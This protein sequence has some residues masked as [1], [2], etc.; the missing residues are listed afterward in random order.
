MIWKRRRD[1][2]SPWQTSPSHFSLHFAALALVD[3]STHAVSLRWRALADPHMF[4]REPC[5][6]T[7]FNCC[8]QLQR[9]V[10]QQASSLSSNTEP[11]PV[12]PSA[13]PS[14]D[15]I[16]RIALFPSASS[17]SYQSVHCLFTSPKHVSFINHILGRFEVIS[18]SIQNSCWVSLLFHRCDVM[19]VDVAV[20]VP[21]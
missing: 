16:H 21:H 20:L 9:P 11:E 10:A 2:E 18:Q 5:V 14:D 6:L 17:E 12:P 1:L 4:L 15:H 13:R 19:H 3:H 8:R 7:D